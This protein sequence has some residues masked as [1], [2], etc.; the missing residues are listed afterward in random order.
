MFEDS[1]RFLPQRH[2]SHLLH[3]PNNLCVLHSGTLAI[4]T[5]EASGVQFHELNISF[6]PASRFLPDLFINSLLLFFVCSFSEF[7][8]V[9]EF[10][11]GNKHKIPLFCTI[12]N[13]S[14]P[15]SDLPKLLNEINSVFYGNITL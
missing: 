14:P 5:P 8:H 9:L 7:F 4:Y 10:L 12:E 2:T 15:S 6:S 11:F 3:S 1:I 13:E